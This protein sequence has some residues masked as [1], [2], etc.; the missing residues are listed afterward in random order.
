VFILVDLSKPGGLVSLDEPENC[1]Q[2]HV[3]VVGG[4]ERDAVTTALEASDAGRYD[5]VGEAFISIAAVRRLAGDRVSDTWQQDF[6][7]MLAFAAT[8]GW[9]DS[10][11]SSIQAHVE[12]EPE[13][14]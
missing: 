1:K 9:L 2:F 8:K 13:T 6:E 3:S 7:A 4:H 11:G 5:G 10:E 14:V 12:W